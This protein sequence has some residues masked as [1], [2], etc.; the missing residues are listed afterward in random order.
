MSAEIKP[1]LI[2]V[3]CEFTRCRD[4]EGGGASMVATRARWRVDSNSNSSENRSEPD[5][6]VWERLGEGGKM[7]GGVGTRTGKVLVGGWGGTPDGALSSGEGTE[8][9]GGVGSPIDTR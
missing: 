4:I 6:D 7:V 9:T 3:G 2:R 8:E 1:E 5:K